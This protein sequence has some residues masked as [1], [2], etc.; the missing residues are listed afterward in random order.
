MAKKQS[1]EDGD[2]FDEAY[3]ANKSLETLSAA[4]ELLSITAP[5]YGNPRLNFCKW[6]IN[7]VLDGY[8]ELI[9]RERKGGNVLIEFRYGEK[10]EELAQILEANS[11]QYNDRYKHFIF[12]ISVQRIP[13]EAEMF[14]SIASLNCRWWLDSGDAD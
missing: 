10:R 5:V 2:S 11:I 3:W 4:K 1:T 7:I 8:N 9:V 13:N 12:A 6:S 14:A